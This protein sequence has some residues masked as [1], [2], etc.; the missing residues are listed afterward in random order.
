M[1]L[2]GGQAAAALLK[3]VGTGRLAA[4]EALLAAE[5]ALV[6]AVG[7]HPF[8]GGRPQPL[9]VAI[10]GK[11]RDMFDLLLDRGADVNG[12]NDGYD[13][14][15]PLMLAINRKR[16]DMRDTL[17][18]RGARVGL[19]EALMLGDDEQVRALLAAGQLP[20]RTPNN[21]SILAFAR[22]AFAID[23]LMALGAPTGR[24]DGWGARPVD[25]ISRLGAPG[26]DLVRHLAALGV[27]VPPQAYARL[28]D[29]RTLETLVQADPAVARLDVVLMAA[30]ESG[31][32]DLVAWLLDVGASPNARSTD[33]S[34]HTALHAAAWNGDA[35]MA[36][37]LLGRG[38]DPAI[39]DEQHRGTP[40][41]WARTSIEVS[42]NPACAAV[43]EL[44]EAR[45]GGGSP[46]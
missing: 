2:T 9:H 42:N 12:T 41:D 39:R 18:A 10:E 6:N 13:G 33:E 45:R 25:A 4:V 1:K 3:S 28:G 23:R 22:T 5:P 34:R 27:S 19:F 35:A 29:R 32:H 11:R 31:H 21:G 20:D 24:A 40:D 37:L 7:P 36:T 44:L 30:V 43:A 16:P 17:L 15:S 46:R 38:A 8:W 26:R 14:W